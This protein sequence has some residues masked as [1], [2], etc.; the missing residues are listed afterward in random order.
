MALIRNHYVQR[1][2]IQPAQSIRH[3]GVRVKHNPVQGILQGK[4]I[5]LVD[6]SIVRGTTLKKIVQMLRGAGAREVHVRISSPP[7]IGPCHYGIDTPTREELIAHGSSVDEIRASIGADSLGYLSLSG[8]RTTAAS[9][10]GGTC[11]AC[12]SDEYPIPVE[13]SDTTPQ[14]NLFRQVEEDDE[15]P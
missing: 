13:S 7:N 15:A 10:K 2:F 4:R 5:V 9:L 12:F 11:D 3:F 14:L 8:L 1:T 6:D